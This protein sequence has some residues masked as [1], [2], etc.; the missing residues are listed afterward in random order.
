MSG[1]WL[2]IS[3]GDTDGLAGICVSHHQAG[4]LKLV[5]IVVTRF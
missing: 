4:H 2:D 5:H 1:Y 3:W